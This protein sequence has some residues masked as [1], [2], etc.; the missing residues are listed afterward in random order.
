M[1][2]CQALVRRSLTWFRSSSGRWR[3]W[4]ELVPGSAGVQS[5]RQSAAVQD[6]RRGKGA[7]VRLLGKLLVAVEDFEVGSGA[8]QQYVIREGDW[9]PEA[10]GTAMFSFSELKCL[11]LGLG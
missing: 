4:P 2:S 6:G 11:L 10:C 3:S 7:I 8:F 5:Q 9:L 1:D